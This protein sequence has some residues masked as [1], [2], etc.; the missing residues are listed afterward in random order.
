M[1]PPKKK[2]RKKERRGVQ[3]ALNVTTST[4]I[5]STQ[6]VQTRPWPSQAGLAHFAI[7]ESALKVRPLETAATADAHHLGVEVGPAYRPRRDC[8]LGPAR[9]CSPKRTR[10]RPVCFRDPGTSVVTYPAAESGVTQFSQTLKSFGAESRILAN[11]GGTGRAC[12]T[13]RRPTHGSRIVSRR[14]QT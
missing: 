10:Q 3:L 4:A 13:K 7:A 5:A 11:S 1:P 12:C 9:E 8:P 6:A 2:K 14:A